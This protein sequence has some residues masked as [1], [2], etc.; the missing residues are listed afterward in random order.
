MF[1]VR[2]ADIDG[3]DSFTTFRPRIAELKTERISDTS[4]ARWWPQRNVSTAEMFI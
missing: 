3:A 2:G 4:L 1:Y